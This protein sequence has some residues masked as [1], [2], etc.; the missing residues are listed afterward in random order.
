MLG[1]GAY[2]G[3]KAVSWGAN[4]IGQG[5]DRVGGWLYKKLH[6]KYAR[7]P[8]KVGYV[9]G[10]PEFGSIDSSAFHNASLLS[11]NRYGLTEDQYNNRLGNVYF[12]K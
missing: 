8:G 2:G 5:I 11:R 1:L 9:H 10:H 6:N 3:Y 7:Q 4:K 12:S